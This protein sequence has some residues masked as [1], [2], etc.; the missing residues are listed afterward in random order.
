MHA[1]VDC[2]ACHFNVDPYEYKTTP[3]ECVRCHHDDYLAAENPD[4]AQAQFATDCEAC[5][6]L[7]APSWYQ[8]DYQHPQSFVLRASHLG[9]DCNGCHSSGFTAT[10]NQC[11]DCHM[12]DYLSS[13]DPDHSKFGFPT[14]CETCHNENRW[15]DAL[16]DHIEAS[17]FEL[18]G[19]HAT[20]QCLSCHV[21]NQITGLPRD[22][23]GCHDDD[24][25][26][27]NDPDHQ[28]GQFSFD[29]LQCHS[30]MVWSPATFDHNGTN[31]PL[32]GAHISVD[33]NSCHING[34]YTGLATDC[35]SC[36]ESE[37]NTTTDP[38]HQAAGFPVQCENCHNTISWDQTTWDHDGQYFPIYTGAHHEAWDTCADCHMVPSDFKQFECIFCHEHNQNDMDEKHKEEQDYQ[39]QSNA[40][41][42]CHPAGKS[43][44]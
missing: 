42:D 2:E 35:L 22:C 44:D 31:F 20:I 32:S 4:H 39:Y 9:V 16:F 40:C 27:V 34:Q 38:N 18:R 33:C 15:E 30:E 12:K 14:I 8:S 17:G 23:I 24:Y 41:Y 29:C 1:I 28:Q 36:H 5:H 26:A 25:K 11:E 10:P 21:N 6:S 43:D 7:A 13:E 37:Y 19:A 3:L